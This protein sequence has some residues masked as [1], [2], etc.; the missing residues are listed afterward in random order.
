MWYPQETYSRHQE[1]V[2]D[3]QTLVDTADGPTD[4]FSTTTF[5]LQRDTLASYLFAIVVDY[6]LHQSVCNISS[7]A[8]LLTPRRST[9]HP[10]K[11]I[12]DQDYADDT[13]LTSD[14]LENAVSPLH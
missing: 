14:N 8:L 2:N 5:I 10:S 3:P 1:N 7:K 12:T 11:Y 4:I 13:A 9:C 6:I